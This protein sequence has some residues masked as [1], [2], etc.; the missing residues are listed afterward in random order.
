MLVLQ[1]RAVLS[2]ALL[3]ALFTSLMPPSDSAAQDRIQVNDEQRMLLVEPQPGPTPTL[4]FHGSLAFNGIRIDRVNFGSL[5][6][7]VG[8]EAGD[9]ITHVNG[10]RMTSIH[11]YRQ[12][13][14]NSQL[15]GGRVQLRIENI[16][17]HW[18]QSNRR[19]VHRQVFLNQG[20]VLLNQPGGFGGVPSP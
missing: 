18:G 2:V 11:V 8:L 17:W 16:R 14:R 7:D 15:N 4:G 19:Y 1:G 3:A 20:P 12:Q 5:A 9:V 10:R 6:A 13:L